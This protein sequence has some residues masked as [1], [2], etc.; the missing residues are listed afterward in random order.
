MN[1]KQ[2][3]AICSMLLRQ[4]AISQQQLSASSVANAMLKTSSMCVL[5]GG[6]TR[7]LHYMPVEQPPDTLPTDK[8]RSSLHKTGDTVSPLFR[9]MASELRRTFTMRT[10]DDEQIELMLKHLLKIVMVTCR[11][12]MLAIIKELRCLTPERASRISR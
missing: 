11:L 7:L 12:H 9:V 2:R 4:G 5:V 10:V 6:W 8:V 3:Q 1:P